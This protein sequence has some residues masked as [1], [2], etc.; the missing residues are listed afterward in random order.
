MFEKMEATRRKRQQHLSSD[1]THDNREM[2]PSSF[3]HNTS[4]TKERLSRVMIKCLLPNTELIVT[5]VT[6][7]NCYLLENR[8][9]LNTLHVW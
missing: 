5:V 9:A 6:K 7:Y 3:T 8:K 2:S 1:S 4:R